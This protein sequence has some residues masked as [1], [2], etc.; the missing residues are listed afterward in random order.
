MLLTWPPLGGLLVGGQLALPL[1]E[2]LERSWRQTCAIFGLLPILWGEKLVRRRE[3]IAPL[4]S[5]LATWPAVALA[6]TAS[7]ARRIG[8]LSSSAEEDAPR[9]I[10]IAS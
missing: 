2:P 9:S 3:F 6:Q 10:S 5:A 1:F 7:R 4:G 8:F